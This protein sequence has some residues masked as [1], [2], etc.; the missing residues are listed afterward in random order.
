MYVSRLNRYISKYVNKKWET[1]IMGK[2]YSWAE[3]RKKFNSLCVSYFI[4]NYNHFTQSRTT[5]LC[6]QFIPYSDET[7]GF[8]V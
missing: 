6:D 3:I 4:V 1:L 5:R 8:Q 2:L 7:V